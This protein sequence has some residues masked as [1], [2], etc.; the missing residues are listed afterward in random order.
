MCNVYIMIECIKIHETSTWRLFILDLILMFLL[1]FCLILM[2]LRV[3]LIFVF[4]F[5]F[6][7]W[8]DFFLFLLL[9]FFFYLSICLFFC[10]FY[11]PWCFFVCSSPISP[12]PPRNCKAPPPPPKIV[13][14]ALILDWVRYF[15]P[16]V[17]AGVKKI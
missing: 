5:L 10:F 1:V 6:L 17:Q 3:F 7:L 15:W 16:N 2:F 9:V 4:F 8:I 13:R 14:F 11:R 12:P